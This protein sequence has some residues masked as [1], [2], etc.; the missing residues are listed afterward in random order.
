MYID[1][2]AKPGKKILSLDG[3]HVSAVLMLAKDNFT[4]IDLLLFSD[5]SDLEQEDS[6]DLPVEKERE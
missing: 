6:D 3:I 1:I 4:R 5:G 2:V